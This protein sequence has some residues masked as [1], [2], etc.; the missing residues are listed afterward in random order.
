MAHI[1]GGR[2]GAPALG[3]GFSARSHCRAQRLGDLYTTL[4]FAGAA[5]LIWLGAQA[6]FSRPPAQQVK[7]MS[8]VTNTAGAY[9]Q[10]LINDLLNP[11]IGVFYTT[12]LPQFIGPG[13]PVFLTSIM[14]AA[15]FAVIVAIWLAIYVEI[16]AKAGEVFHRPGV[17]WAMERITGVVLVGLGIRLVMEQR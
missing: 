14:L 6:L 9:R 2:L 10:G 4:R 7:T 17:R 16:L 3:P 5:Y 8:P 11:K 12:F 1:A 13:Q 15:I